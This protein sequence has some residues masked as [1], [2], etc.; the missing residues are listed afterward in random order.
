MSRKSLLCLYAVLSCCLLS[1]C[2]SSGTTSAS[3]GASAAGSASDYLE[4]EIA[5]VEI[6][7]IDPDLSDNSGTIMLGALGGAMLGQILTGKSSG[8]LLGTGLGAAVAGIG[9]SLALRMDGVRLTIDT[10]LG[11]LTED[12]PFSC[13]YRK[14]AKVRLVS[15]NQGGEIQVL[16]NGSYVAAAPENSSNCALHYQNIQNGQEA[17]A[18]LPHTRLHAD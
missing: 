9:T 6:V 5:G 13:L 16:D 3:G 1:A 8:T 14:G 4:G 2:A 15:N 11:R 12:K 10:D 17:P 18:V 7:D